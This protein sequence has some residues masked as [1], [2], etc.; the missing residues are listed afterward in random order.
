[1][2]D[3]ASGSQYFDPS[4]QVHMSL[5]YTLPQF[6][7]SSSNSAT[8]GSSGGL[9]S[10]IENRKPKKKEGSNRSANRGYVDGLNQ[11]A[12]E[13]LRK[14]RRSSARTGGKKMG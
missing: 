5:I 7:S 4:F 14:Q 9:L 3:N 11:E 13:R 1:M 2:S 12:E 10:R 8:N 6:V